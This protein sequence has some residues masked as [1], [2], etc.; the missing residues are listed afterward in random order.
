MLSLQKKEKP[1]GKIPLINL[2][3]LVLYAFLLLKVQETFV[4]NLND[5]DCRWYYTKWLYIQC[6]NDAY[7]SL[8][9]FPNINIEIVIMT[10]KR[11]VLI[12]ATN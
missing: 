9:P 5:F 10:L 8:F 7:I 3:T 1:F 12:L 2:M 6:R 11:W 4:F